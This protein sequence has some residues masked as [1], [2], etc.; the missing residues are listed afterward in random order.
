MMKL[1]RKVV[2]FV[3][4]LTI[5]CSLPLSVC[6]LD[7]DEVGAFFHKGFYNVAESLVEGLLRGI[8]SLLPTPRGWKSPDNN[9]LSGHMR[10]TEPWLQSPAKDAVFSLG[11]NETSLLDTLPVDIHTLYVGGSID[12]DEKKASALLDDLRVRTAALSDGSGRGTGVLLELDAYGLSLPDVR[13]IRHRLSAYCEEAGIHSITVA[14]LHQHSAADTFGMNGDIFRIV[15][16]NPILTALSLPT[17]NGKHDIYMEHLFETCAASIQAAVAGMKQGK[18]YYGTADQT[19]FLIDKRAP[20]VSDPHFNRFRFVPS[21]GSRETWLVSTEIHCVGNGA[22]GT[23]LTSDYPFYAER[24]I[25]RLANANV[26][27][28]MGAQQSTTG[29]YDES[30]IPALRNTIERTDAIPVF[31]DAIGQALCAITE[32]VEVPPLF[33]VRFA[34][35]ILPITNPVLLLA[36]KAG[37]I[38]ADV[39]KLENGYGVVTEIGYAE[40]GADF[41]FAIIPGELAPELAYGGCLGKDASWSGKDWTYPS[42][43]E[44][45]AAAGS[46]RK[47]FALDLAN[48]Q[49]GYIVPD[50]NYMPMI[51]PES[52]SIEF[53]SLGKQT[54]SLLMDAYQTLIGRGV[55]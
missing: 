50:N 17:T 53:V 15:L 40:L 26:L 21:D 9:T 35:M 45:V 27:F 48:D 33:N 2:A 20:Y 10:G 22:G 24:T 23:V 34:S 44:M 38:G 37:M 14:V 42:L 28:Y 32:E 12:F 39:V 51:A 43:Q 18:L 16:R 7:K 1:C 46:S 11:F 3:L 8:S 19:P 49:I 36:G 5:V 47:L 54:A 55:S 6:A 31:G 52:N 41:A 30:R 13:E 29:N 4:A 25:R